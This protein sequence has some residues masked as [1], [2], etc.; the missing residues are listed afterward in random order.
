MFK[1]I[2]DLSD[3]RSPT[4]RPFCSPAPRSP[5]RT[6]HGPRLLADHARPS[7]CQA[8]HCMAD[9][10]H[11][12]KQT[13]IVARRSHEGELTWMQDAQDQIRTFWRFHSLFIRSILHI[14]VQLPL[15]FSLCSFSVS[16]RL[17]GSYQRVAGVSPQ[18]V[19]IS[20]RSESA[21]RTRSRRETSSKRHRRPRSGAWRRLSRRHHRDSSPFGGLRRRLVSPRCFF[22]LIRRRL[23][24]FVGLVDVRFFERC[25][26]STSS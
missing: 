7:P 26:A 3:S 4:R 10:F 1:A 23:L 25:S 11:P 14:H 12:M 19:T 5:D 15:S 16:P 20:E 8:D 18:G 22:S 13:S 24:A 2:R 17:R 9:S 6:L 21:S